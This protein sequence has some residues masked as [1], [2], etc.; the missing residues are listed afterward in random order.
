MF[1]YFPSNGIYMSTIDPGFLIK[2]T[3][4]GTDS[5]FEAKIKMKIEQ[6]LPTEDFKCKEHD[7]TSVRTMK[8]ILEEHEKC[9]V[10]TF[11]ENWSRRNR[12]CYPH[13]LR[14]YNKTD[15]E[16][17]DFAEKYQINDDVYP[18]M[19][20]TSSRCLT[21]CI[22]VSFIKYSFSLSL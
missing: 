3:T 12:S 11:M 8:T 2:Q 21:P 19:N 17:C 5:W 6:K 7:Y 4:I 15:T 10:E 1:A 14:N 18:A 20:A 22:G 16:F 13:I 9:M